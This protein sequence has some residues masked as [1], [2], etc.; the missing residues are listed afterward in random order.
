MVAAKLAALSRLNARKPRANR[1]EGFVMQRAI[2]LSLGLLLWGASGALAQFPPQPSAPKCPGPAQGSA[3]D[4]AACHPDV[5]KLCQTE[6]R[7]NE[8]DVFAILGC[9]QRNRTRL[10][11]ACRHVLEANGR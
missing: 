5:V 6:L 7:T 10:S 9:L 11:A 2:A 4:R 8:C 3:Q 1:V